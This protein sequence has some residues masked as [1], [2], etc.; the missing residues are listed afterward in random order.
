ME[1]IGTHRERRHIFDPEDHASGTGVHTFDVVDAPDSEGFLGYAGPVEGGSIEVWESD[2]LVTWTHKGTALSGDDFRWATAVTTDGR[3]QVVVR[4]TTSR[5]PLLRSQRLQLYHSDDG[6]S[7]KAGETLVGDAP[8]GNPANPFLTYDEH[9]GDYVLVYYET[10]TEDWKIW[11]R[12]ATS[13]P[14]LAK[15]PDRLLLDGDS[16]IAAPALLP[17]PTESEYVLFAEST[18]DDTGRWTTVA[19]SA[20]SLDEF[21]DERTVL[22]LEDEA[23]PFP[24]Y[25][26]GT[27]YLFT[28]QCRGEHAAGEIDAEWDGYIHQY[29]I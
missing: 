27:L 1:G 16:F 5:I 24:F 7:F 9:T 26:D 23:C 4:E 21:T 13:V 29:D 25:E 20:P 18:D 14:G 28:S 6:V 11:C 17:H 22:F 8:A 3:V 12:R 10:D 15:S 2:D 19:L